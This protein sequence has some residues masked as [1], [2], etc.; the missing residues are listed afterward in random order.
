MAIHADTT[1]RAAPAELTMDEVQT[2]HQA[3]RADPSKAVIGTLLSKQDLLQNLTQRDAEVADTQVFNLK[4][5]S[6]VTPVTN[7]KS[8]GRCWLFATTNCA[9]LA[10]AKRYNVT[11]FQFSQSYLFFWDKLEKANFYLENMIDLVEE[12]LDSRIVQYLNQSPENDGGQWDMAVNLLDKYGLV[13]QS[14]YPETWHSSNS[15]K[16]DKLIT[17]KLRE[18]SLELREIYSSRLSSLKDEQSLAHLSSETLA[19]MAVKACRSR[20][21]E[22]MSEIYTMLAMMC[23]VPPKA[24]EKLTYE[25]YDKD[26]K[27]KSIKATP[28][29]LYKS[30]EGSF[31][32]SDCISLINDPRNESNKLYTVQRLGNVWNGRPVLYV[33]TE[34]ETL[35]DTIVKMLKADMPV[36][37]GCD[38]GQF[39]NTALGIM[40][41]K[42][43]DY[44]QTFGTGLGMSK[45]QRLQTGE[46]SMTHAMV[47]VAAHLDENGKPV[48]FR[49]ENSWADTAGTKGYF[50][51]SN[52]WLREYVYQIVV[53]KKLAPP[54]LVKVFEGGKPVELPPW[55]P[56]GSLA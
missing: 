3:Y 25:F 38:V 20:K 4:L 43:F 15:G 6:E 12:D 48:R 5:S 56:M 32:A 46:S 47:I 8:S 42:L 40:D 39:S 1:G 18:Y 34:S 37:F 17:S 24:D 27:F 21:T 54:E 41:T 33:N 29:E 9:R 49:V 11:D 51:M 26:K 36:W 7:Q 23:G 14:L 45:A 31:K 35:E 10:F 50:V 2:W 28:K 44:K 53:P 30:L 13:P 16:L 55:D 19:D 22:Q 52:E